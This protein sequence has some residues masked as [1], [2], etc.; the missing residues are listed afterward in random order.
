MIVE[1][2]YVW[3]FQAP[4]GAKKRG[5]GRY[6]YSL[7]QRILGGCGHLA[8]HVTM[9]F[10]AENFQEHWQNIFFCHLSQNNNTPD[11]VMCAAKAALQG[12][13]V[14]LTPLPRTK[15]LEV[16]LGVRTS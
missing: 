14:N 4:V 15:I 5:C 1:E 7:K 10:L 2:T 8:N 12:K 13:K 9:K 6:H 3:L 11:T 16:K